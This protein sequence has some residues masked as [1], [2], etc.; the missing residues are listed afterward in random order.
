MDKKTIIIIGLVI[1]I[2][3]MGFILWS[4]Q[5][6]SASYEVLQEMINEK[7]KENVRLKKQVEQEL[8]VI[9]ELESKQDSL[10]LLEGKIEYRYSV[11]YEKNNS[12][13]ANALA[14][15]FEAIFASHHVK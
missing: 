9:K 7:T 4:N 10:V 6:S 15:K 1:V 11:R 3:V 5:S 14:D 12:L 13:P 8:S 2:A